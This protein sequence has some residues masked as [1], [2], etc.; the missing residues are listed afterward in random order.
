MDRNSYIILERKIEMNQQFRIYVLLIWIV[1]LFIG[2]SCKNDQKEPNDQA[3][4]NVLIESKKLNFSGQKIVMASNITDVPAARLLADWFYKET[5]GIILIEP[6][7]YDRMERVIIEDYHSKQSKYDVMEITYFSLARLVEEGVVLDLSDLIEQNKELI[8]PEDFYT[9]LYDAYT[10]YKGKRWGV[11]Y[12]VDVH[13]FF[14]RKSLLKK[15]GFSPPDTWDDVNII[16]K[17][18]TEK[19]KQNGIHGVAMMG[20]PVPIMNVCMYFNRLAAYGGSF[21]DSNG[22]PCINSPEAILALEKVIELSPYA[23]PSVFDTDYETSRDAFLTGKV[24]MLDQ[25]SSLGTFAEDISISL[26]NNDWGVVIMPKGTGNKAIHPATLNA[27]YSLTISNKANN[28]ELAKAF[29]LFASRPDI[30]KQLNISKT[31]IDPGRMSVL[32]S[33]D[34]IKSFLMAKPIENAF[35]NGNIKGW[36][37]IPEVIELMEILSKNITFAMK[38]VKSAK[39]AL[40]DT[41]E[42]WLNILKESK[43]QSHRDHVE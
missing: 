8:Q 38:N 31:G 32:K 11:P 14:Y 40:D 19:E 10:L 36:P 13:L 26:V 12:D 1:T 17:V 37:L 24:A 35:T 30:Q 23:L 27:G 39:Q 25:W 16:A 7:P 43:T 42:L 6:I 2:T 3:K 29:I 15:Y 18:I 33:Q 9:D 5:R 22:T 34:F 4:E 41:Q 21:I 28:L 20:Y